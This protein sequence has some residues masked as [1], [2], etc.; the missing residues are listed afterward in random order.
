MYSSREAAAVEP[1]QQEVPD[2]G[3]T[4][5]QADGV[6]KGSDKGRVDKAAERGGRGALYGLSERCRRGRT[7]SSAV[8]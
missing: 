1:Q 6:G 4:R 5:R 7:R 3:A 8:V 2:L